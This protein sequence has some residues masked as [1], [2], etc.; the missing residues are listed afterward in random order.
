VYYE[1]NKKSKLTI[2]KIHLQAAVAVV[3]IL[4]EMAAIVVSL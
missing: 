1:E 2:K 3:A 4:S